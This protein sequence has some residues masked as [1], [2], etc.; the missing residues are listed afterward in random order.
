LDRRHE[1][2]ARTARRVR[3]QPVS[4]ATGRRPAGATT[5]RRSRW[6]R[7]RAS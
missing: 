3:A 5:A 6:R 2:S 7:C 4:A 1:E